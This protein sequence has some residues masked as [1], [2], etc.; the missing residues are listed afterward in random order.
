MSETSGAGARLLEAEVYRLLGRV[1]IGA[2]RH[3]VLGPAPS[4]ED[5]RRA[6][7][8]VGSDRVVVK[9][10][11]ADIVHKTEVGGVAFCAGEGEAVRAAALEVV[12]RARAARPDA[13][14]DG[15][16]VCERV[17]FPD[18]PGGEALLSLRQDP[19]FGPV[20]VLGLGGVLTEWYGALGPG[21]STWVASA[22]DPRLRQ[23]PPAPASL[24]PG[25]ALLAAPSRLYPR[26]PFCWEALW[27][28]VRGLASIEGIDEL[29]VNPL[30]P[31]G[32][33]VVALDGVARLAG[34]QGPRRP[35]RP[36]GAID[37]L[38][39][40]RS[41]AVIGASGRGA[42]A[43]RVIL[44]NLREA[45]GLELR[46][47][48]PKETAIDGVPCVAT[49]ADLS[50][51]D[52]AVVSVPAD[53]ARDAI[54]D[55][56][57]GS[58]A[59]SLI[60]IPGGF[61]ETGDRGLAAEITGILEGSR[62]RT[63]GGPVL[64]GANCLGVVAKGRYNTFFLPRVKLPWSDA[65]G[66][67]LL[68]L[69]QSGAYLVTLGS[70]LDGVVSPRAAISYGNQMDL[71]V[72][73][74]L[75]HA[76]GDPSVRVITC[77]I[78]GFE[79]LDGLRFVDLVRRHRAAGRAVLVYKAGRTQAAAAAAAS[80]TASLAGDWEVARA[81]LAAAGALVA[82]S[83]DELQ[84]LTVAFTLLGNHRPGRRVGVLSNAGFEC[85]S[86]MDALG[87]LEVARLC[88]ET[89][90]RLAAQLP[91]MAHADNPIDATPMATTEQFVGA[92]EALVADPGVDVVVVSAVPVTPAL[93]VL[94]RDPLGRH[95]ED[96]EAA[97]SLPNRIAGVVAS[98][99][100]PVV[101]AIDSG[102]LYDPCVTVLQRAGIPTWRRIDR[103]MRALGA[104]CASHL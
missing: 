42:N 43:G 48:H 32:G 74:L 29:E 65:P 68:C 85:S 98:T 102:A 57:D 52:L 82:E 69:S 14:V 40:P 77:Y 80:H 46:A 28:A 30:V 87:G 101:A 79:P 72:A 31:R 20:V 9:V 62:S 24:G 16:L 59:R 60:L 104:W 71:T 86:A 1:G 78:E 90:A 13:R 44:Q 88:E 22:T 95:G 10:H 35:P 3:A 76:L 96:V 8:A 91:P 93:D 23:G 61:A 49:V 15:V 99:R 25:V 100:K 6:V 38:L 21:R 81:L 97:G 34:T 33:G 53:A 19:A 51:V 70:N 64:V 4:L 7:E 92:L 37:T 83:L 2:P 66:D 5:A 36:L 58:K 50:P 73:D 94:P 47:V 89:R 11:A 18:G 56:V 84:D 67:G 45:P 103:A 54:R 55:L 26:P 63:D 17:S 41:A 27:A 39:A 12:A 75:E